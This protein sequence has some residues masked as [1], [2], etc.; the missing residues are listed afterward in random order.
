MKKKIISALLCASMVASMAAGCG[1]SDTA[2]T[3]TTDNTASTPATEAAPAADAGTEAATDATA[4]DEGKVLNIYCW[5]EEF[6]SRL[7]DHYP[8]YTIVDGTTGTIGDVTVKWN[9]TPNDDNAYQNNLDATLLKQ[10][11]AAADDKIDLFLIEAD[12]ALKYVD[13]DYTMAVKDLGI[14]DA[15]LADQYQYTKDI[16]T[17]DGSQRGTTWQATPGLFA[18]RRSIAKDVLG[19]DDPTEV[20]TYLSDWDKFNDVAAQASAKGYKMLSGFDDAYRTFSNNVA[21]PWVTGTTVTVDEN[22]MKWVDQTKEYTDKGYNNKSSLWDSQWA[23]DQGPNGKV[24]G[25]FYSTWGINFTLLGNSLETPTSEG[26]KEEVGNGIYGDYAVCE[27]PQPYYW[28]GTWICGAAGS[29][30]LD[31]IKDVMQ[32]LTCDEAIMKQITLDTQDYTNN[33]KAMEEIASSDYKSDFLGGQNHIALFAEAAK[34]IDMSNAGPYDQG[35]NESFQTA[36][37]DYFTGNVDEDTAKANFETAIKEKYPE[38]T[39]VVW[40]A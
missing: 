26:G 1:S 17:V 21:A 23:S 36:F 31:T 35:L 20:Q 7:E 34:K 38:L 25:F 40:P 14:T 30:N 10:A 2:D 39:D 8:G 37:K 6:K 33:E 4:A 28:G 9:I 12:Y 5:N 29:D 11:D 15:D 18:Y 13:T 16:V 3:T 27:G 19:T 24:F 22:I 32:K